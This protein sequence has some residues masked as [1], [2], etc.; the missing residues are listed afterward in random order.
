MVP[1]KKVPA[2]SLDT[3]IL[4]SNPHENEQTDSTVF[5]FPFVYGGMHTSGHK[6]ILHIYQAYMQY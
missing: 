3:W 2:E 1:Q 4:P 6:N 5:W